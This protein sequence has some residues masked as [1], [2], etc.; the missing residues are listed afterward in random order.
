MRDCA[1]SWP[2][3]GWFCWLPFLHHIG[4]FCWLPIL[5]CRWKRAYASAWPTCGWICCLPI[6]HHIWLDLLSSYSALHEEEG[7]CQLLVYVWLDLLASFFSLHMAGFVDFLF[8]TAG[9][10]GHMPAPGLRVA[11]SVGFLFFTTYGWFCWL[12]ILHCRWKRDCASSWPTCGWF[13]RLPIL[14]HIWLDLSPSYFA[15][16]VEEGLCQLLAYVWLDLSASFSSP[17]MAGSVGFLFCT[18][19]GWICWLPILHHIWLVLLA[20]CSALQVEEGLCQLLAYVWLDRE[21]AKLGRDA[22]HQRQAS[23]FSYQ[24]RTV[25]ALLPLRRHSP[26]SVI[27]RP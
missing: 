1:S 24:I 10:R 2:T 20:S 27:R 22:M 4:W 16:Q 17:H 26:L 3:C 5:H 9:G 21:H 19:Y 23:F 11:G 15:L 25:S 6:L 8:C 18:T 14:Q 12:P 7:L 13:C